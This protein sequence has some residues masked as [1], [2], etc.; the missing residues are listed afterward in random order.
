MTHR[1]IAMLLFA[2]IISTLFASRVAIFRYGPHGDVQAL[3]AKERKVGCIRW[4]PLDDDQLR[5]KVAFDQCEEGR[6]DDIKIQVCRSL[7]K[8]D[9]YLNT[10][11]IA[12]GTD[13]IWLS[14]KEE[15]FEELYRIMG[16][17]GRHLKRMGLVNNAGPISHGQYRLMA[18]YTGT[19]RY[20]SRKISEDIKKTVSSSLRE[21]NVFYHIGQYTPKQKYK[22]KYEIVQTDSVT[23]ATAEKIIDPNAKILLVSFGNNQQPGGKYLQGSIAQESDI[24]RRTTI[25]HILDSDEVRDKCYPINDLKSDV[26]RVVHTPNVHV[27]RSSEKSEFQFLSEAEILKYRIDLCTVSALNKNDPEESRLFNA[28]GNLTREGL[29][30]TRKRIETT[31]QLAVK[32]KSDVLITGA[33]GCGAYDNDPFDIMDAFNEVIEKYHGAIP[34]V[35]FAVLGKDEYQKFRF[36]LSFT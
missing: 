16:D 18:V 22:T 28:S 23:A 14:E 4:F 17:L 12:N 5:R 29:E 30:I 27:M 36:G 32:S 7:V 19:S 35:I 6:F 1:L 21:T 3:I 33:F 24:F 20:T 8:Y 26:T 15:R 25:S 34:K 10:Q 9:G 31:F 2:L 11:V 13:Y